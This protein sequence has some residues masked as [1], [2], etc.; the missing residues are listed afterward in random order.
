MAITANRIWR[1]MPQETRIAASKACW[2]ESTGAAKQSLFAFLA[3]A[4]NLREVTVRKTP[5]ERLVNWTAATLSLP[6]PIVEELLKKYLL[7]DH[8]AVIVS[9]LELLKIPHAEGMIEE[10]F[11]LATL[12][13]EQ[14]QTPARSLLESA[15]RAGALL[16]LNYLV[17]QGGAWAAIEQVLPAGE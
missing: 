5:M 2:A 13:N 16:Y 7:R 14:V 11:D 6:D 17:L 1:Q 15:D 10:S 12:S 9:F 4:K 8:R 3:K